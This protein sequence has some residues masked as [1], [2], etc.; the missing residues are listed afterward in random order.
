MTFV[1]LSCSDILGEQLFQGDHSET[2][3]SP[4]GEVTQFRPIFYVGLQGNI[5]LADIANDLQSSRQIKEFYEVMCTV[6]TDY[7]LQEKPLYL[8]I[9]DCSYLRYI[10]NDNRISEKEYTENVIT[11]FVDAAIVTN[12][13]PKMV[14]DLSE[15]SLEELFG[16]CMN[17]LIVVG[18]YETSHVQLQQ[19]T[20]RSDYSHGVPCDTIGTLSDLL[21][22]IGLANGSCLRTDNIPMALSAHDPPLFLATDFKAWGETLDHPFCKRHI[23]FPRLRTRWGNVTTA[24]AF[25]DWIS[26]QSGECTFLNI[27]SGAQYVIIALPKCDASWP[28]ITMPSTDSDSDDWD[29]E[30][31]LLEEG[32]NM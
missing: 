11:N 3:W 4:T 12:D 20:T 5:P 24:G 1:T 17:D 26:P 16:S 9:P 7:G 14:I 19:L 28:P 30:G 13:V 32:M 15:G 18:M 2:L 27:L 6:E 22:S 31:V 8:S 25:T 23:P 29:F 21:C 10:E